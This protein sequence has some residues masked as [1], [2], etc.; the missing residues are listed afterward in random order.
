MAKAGKTGK[1]LKGI[2]LGFALMLAGIWAVHVLD[3]DAGMHA[4][5]WKGPDF[6][7]E[8]AVDFAGHN[9]RSAMNGEPCSLN[10]WMLAHFA[11]YAALTYAF[12]QRCLE[13]FCVGVAW[14]VGEMLVGVSQPMD[15]IWNGLGVAVGSL[16]ASMI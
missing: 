11:A 1:D 9:K 14:E 4:C 6:T 10:G 16:A 8:S 15:I 13:I 2:A 12:P 3:W 5:M 7:A